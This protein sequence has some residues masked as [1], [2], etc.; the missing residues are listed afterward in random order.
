MLLNLSDR[1]Y[2]IASRNIRLRLT[3]LAY[4][5]DIILGLAVKRVAGQRAGLLLRL[6][7]KPP[8][9]SPITVQVTTIAIKQLKE[10]TAAI[11]LRG[12]PYF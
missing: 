10:E 6:P 2:G 5:G 1:F 11:R 8:S 4:R 9:K 7:T 12:L 3:S